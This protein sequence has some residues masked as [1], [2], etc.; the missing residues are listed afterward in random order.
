MRCYTSSIPARVALGHSHN[1]M[2]LAKSVQQFETG[3]L[4]VVTGH[5]SE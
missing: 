3:R 1:D 5:G 2:H 4:K